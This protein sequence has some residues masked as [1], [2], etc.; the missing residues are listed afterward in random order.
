MITLKNNRNKLNVRKLLVGFR[1]HEAAKDRDK[2]RL[3][4]HLVRV[5]PAV[6][7]S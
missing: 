4:P 3:L 5:N 1:M 2:A 6:Q 7:I